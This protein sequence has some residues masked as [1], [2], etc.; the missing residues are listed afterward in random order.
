MLRSPVVPLQE[1]TVELY[2]SLVVRPERAL[3][4]E[5]LLL[6]Q[7]QRL[8]LEV[9]RLSSEGLLVLPPEVLRLLREVCLPR[10]A[11]R[12]VL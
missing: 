4:S 5:E 3:A 1:A 7:E 9:P 10:I 6:L 11:L 8:L 12:E 2:L